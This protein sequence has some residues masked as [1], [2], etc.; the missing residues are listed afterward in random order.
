MARRWLWLAAVIGGYLLGGAVLAVGSA[1]WI[2]TFRPYSGYLRQDVSEA[3]AIWERTAAPAWPRPGVNGAV[4]AASQVGSKRL[5]D[6]RQITVREAK[7]SQVT[8]TVLHT[9]VGWP[10]RSM[11]ST[12]RYRIDGA[13]QNTAGAGAAITE[14]GEDALALS[15]MLPVVGTVRLALPVTPLWGG[16]VVNALL[17]A[18]AAGAIVWSLRGARVLVR[19]WRGVCLRCRYDLKGAYSEGCPECGWGRESRPEPVA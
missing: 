8:Y 5:T 9:R 4:L 1:W 12:T 7:G 14:I 16:L 15:A 17:F 13:K 18:A 6:T 3:H 10:R 2:A 11:T 19:R